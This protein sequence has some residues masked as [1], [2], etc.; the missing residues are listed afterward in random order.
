MTSEQPYPVFE[1][2]ALEVCPTRPRIRCRRR[3]RTSP[4]SGTT[5]CGARSRPTEAGHER[6]SDQTVH[7]VRRG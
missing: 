5:R 4:G 6:T 7:E 2:V 1:P 3:P